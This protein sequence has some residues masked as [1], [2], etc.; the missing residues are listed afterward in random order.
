MPCITL[1]LGLAAGPLLRADDAVRPGDFYVEPA[2]FHS[3]G[4]QWKMAGDD[5][6]NARVAVAYRADGSGP[7][8]DGMDLLRIDGEVFGSNVPEKQYTCGNLVAGSI[9]FLKP[10]TRYEVRLA[11][12]DP[13]NGRQPV[14]RNEK[15][16]QLICRQRPG[17]CFA[18]ISCVPFSVPQASVEAGRKNQCE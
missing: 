7:W 15:G 17:G 4:F 10:G 3:L 6:R 5:N 14:E 2:T 1:L 8:R 16:T 9:L 11:L 13:D 18:Q 12:S